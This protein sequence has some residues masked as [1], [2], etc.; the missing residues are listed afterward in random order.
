MTD[1]RDKFIGKEVTAAEAFSAIYN[2]PPYRL[3]RLGEHQPEKKF[4]NVKHGLYEIDYG[5]DEKSGPFPYDSV[6]KRAMHAAIILAHGREDDREV[7]YLR[8]CIRPALL[9]AT[10]VPK[11]G[12]NLWELPA[13]LVDPG[14]T[15]QE[16]AQRECVEELGFEYAVEKFRPLGAPTFP[17]VG[18][19][20]EAL[21]FF[22]IEVNPKERKDPT[23]DGSPIEHGGWIASVDL[24]HALQMAEC[25]LLI[26]MKTEFALL[27]YMRNR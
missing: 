16:A 25:G 14:E 20:G 1:K 21:H 23:C 17:A 4:L 7:I 19:C 10:P 15:P 2:L 6:I 3:T 18:I 27:R 11:D 24:K 13:G 5:L 8:S 9:D 22:E 12:A 26:D